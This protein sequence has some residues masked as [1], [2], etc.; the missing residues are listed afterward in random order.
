MGEKEASFYKK[1]G[2]QRVQCKLCPHFCILK[3]NERGKCKARI[4]KSGKLISL[5]YGRAITLALDPIEKKPLYHFLPGE[6]TLSVATAGCNLSCGH[7]QN[8]EISQ[9][10][11]EETPSLELK[12]EDVVKAAERKKTNIISYTYTEPT[13]FYEYAK[14]IAVLAKARG[15]K[16]V[17]VTNGFI[18]KEPLKELCNYI[19]A[20]N[21]DLKSISDE[22]YKDVCGAKLPPILEAIKIMH[23]EIWIEITN[24]II[25]GLNDNE[26]EIKKLVLWVKSNLGVNVPLHFS[27]F[28]PT[29]KMLDLPPTSLGI[30]KKAREI[31]MNEGLNFVYTGNILDETGNNTYCPECKKLIIK[32]RGFEVLENYI[33]K[34]RCP[35][36]QEKIAGVWD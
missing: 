33:E 10:K 25:P 27:A 17:T 6:K 5:V 21:I 29:Y 24:L 22:F 19:H 20:S 23:K 11:P 1:L 30:L 36:C 4:N 32:R 14:D 18:N 16:N 15:M 31:A 34:S 7:C 13:I 28:Y 26:K 35:Y 12:P 9:V 3:N 8:F 2:E